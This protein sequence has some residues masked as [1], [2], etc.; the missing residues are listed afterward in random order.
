MFNF[1]FFLKS[2]AGKRVFIA[3]S[4]L[5]SIVMYSLSDDDGTI[6][7]GD[8]AALISGSFSLQVTE[9]VESAEGVAVQA[10]LTNNT[11]KEIL[12]AIG[13]LIGKDRYSNFLMRDERQI[14]EES[15]G[16]L[17]PH[18]SKEV[19]FFLWET[20]M[21]DLKYLSFRAAFVEFTES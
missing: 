13:I 18:A 10:L 6:A 16:S 4:I 9:T 14:I 11:D 2:K 12:S 15:S 5:V 21:D 19:R 1:L 7:I 3:M 8:P 17:A 20:Y